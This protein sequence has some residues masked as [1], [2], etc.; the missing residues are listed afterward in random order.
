MMRWWLRKC[1]SLAL[2]IVG[3]GVLLPTSVGAA[4]D[5][6]YFASFWDVTANGTVFGPTFHGPIPGLNKPIVGMA[7][8]PSGSGYWLVASDGGVFTFDNAQFHG[9][10]ANL[11]LNRPIVGMASTPSGNG[12]WLVAS[13]GGVFAFGDAQFH[14]SAANLTLIRPIVGMASTPS[15]NGYW[16]VASD[17]GVFA[18]GDAQF[19][20]SLAI[21]H[22]NAPIE[23]ITAGPDGD[24]Y[25]LD[26]ADGGIFA[27]GGAKFFG[28]IPGS[29]GSVAGP[30]LSTPDGGG[31]WLS[32]QGTG[33]CDAFGDAEECVTAAPA[34]GPDQSPYVYPLFVGAAAKAND[35]VQIVGQN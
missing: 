30:V 22:L 4:N 21:T 28:S 33:G 6:P 17:G 9:S 13:D 2:A 20:G 8:T 16:L 32:L 23:G 34:L 14:G 3:F 31:Y 5:M 25:W 24:G 15:G 7:S 19:Y 12:Y 10:A 29:P 26:G 1:A 35:E 18:F 27:F 11:T